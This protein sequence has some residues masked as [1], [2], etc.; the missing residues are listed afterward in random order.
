[1]SMSQW[2]ESI[3]GPSLMHTLNKHREPGV[4]FLEPGGGKQRKAQG[5]W[6]ATTA[7][8]YADFGKLVS[9]ETSDRSPLEFSV[10]FQKSTI[11]V[12]AGTELLSLGSASCL[13]W[14]P[15]CMPVA[16]TALM[17]T[18]NEGTVTPSVYSW[19]LKSRT[20]GRI[21]Q[22][23]L[24]RSSCFLMSPKTSPSLYPFTPLFPLLSRY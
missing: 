11:P 16:I 7:S 15:L 8:W 2:V 18:G 14:P 10:L 21:H 23:A 20:L 19:K 13:S 24:T 9:W 22:P 3:Q 4:W 17:I 1:M 5:F 12:C 6:P